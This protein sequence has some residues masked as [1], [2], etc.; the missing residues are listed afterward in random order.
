MC[1]VMNS[2]PDDNSRYDD[3]H[4]AGNSAIRY[5]WNISTT[6]EIS[7]SGKRQ[8]CCVCFIDMINSTKIAADLLDVEIY[9][10]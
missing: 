7:F 9:I 8:N 6:E 3:F 2:L 1:L 10:P 5:S 4:I